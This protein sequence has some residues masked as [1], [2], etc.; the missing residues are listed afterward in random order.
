[1]SFDIFKS[2][3][4]N[5]RKKWQKNRPEHL[6]LD[7]KQQIFYKRNDVIIEPDNII[8]YTLPTKF[9]VKLF[10]KNRMTKNDVKSHHPYR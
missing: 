6:N 5:S 4:F 8:L 7:N 9:F 1:M 10:L 2:L 3:C